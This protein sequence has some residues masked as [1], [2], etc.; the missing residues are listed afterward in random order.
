MP[1]KSE[2]QKKLMCAEAAKPGSTAA[3][4][5]DRKS[6]AEFCHTPGKLPAKTTP[7]KGK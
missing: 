1:A 7:K 3:K 2:A 6:A 5:I 4:G